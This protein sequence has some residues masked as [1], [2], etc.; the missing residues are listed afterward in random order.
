[1]F[2]TLSEVCYTNYLN[3][4]YVRN[5]L[6]HYS[7]ALTRSIHKY[8][9][10]VVDFLERLIVRTGRSILASIRLHK[11]NILYCNKIM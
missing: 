8:T 2:S 11:L 7:L 10:S 9:M 3:N 4:S 1:M 5:S 6:G